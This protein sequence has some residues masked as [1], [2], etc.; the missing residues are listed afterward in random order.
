[1]HKILLLTII[2]SLS[3]CFNSPIYTP[4][5]TCYTQL[6]ACPIAVIGSV[7]AGGACHCL[8]YNTNISAPGIAR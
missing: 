4:A 7:P 2:I 1:M 3:G 8:N 6:G 5:T